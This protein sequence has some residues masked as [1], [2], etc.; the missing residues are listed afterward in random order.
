MKEQTLSSGW[1]LVRLIMQLTHTSEKCQTCNPGKICLTP[2]PKQPVLKTLARVQP[3]ESTPAGAGS[4]WWDN[5]SCRLH[6][7]VLTTEAQKVLFA[8]KLPNALDW[9]GKVKRH[10]AVMKN[11]QGTFNAKITFMTPEEF[12]SVWCGLI[13]MLRLKSIGAQRNVNFAD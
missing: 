9:I 13:G 12:Q 8:G 1:S 11:I 10:S 5:K 2:R 7:H 6:A 3:P 4:R